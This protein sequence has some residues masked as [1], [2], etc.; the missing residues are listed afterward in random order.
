VNWCT[1]VYSDTTICSSYYQSAWLLQRYAIKAS[2]SSWC[3]ACEA[4]SVPGK[5]RDHRPRDPAKRQQVFGHNNRNRNTVRIAAC[6]WV[7]TLLSLPKRR[8]LPNYHHYWLAAYGSSID[9]IIPWSTLI[10]LPKIKCRVNVNY[11]YSK[12]EHCIHYQRVMRH[13]RCTVTVAAREV[14]C[15]RPIKAR[16]RFK[17]VPMVTFNL[18]LI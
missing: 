1:A 2:T 4:L 7:F 10:Y 13:L 16:F 11:N 12:L 6:W 3:A 18:I 17:I 14:Q 15:R 9:A 5:G 8:G